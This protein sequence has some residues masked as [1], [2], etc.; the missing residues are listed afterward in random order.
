ME[1][2]ELNQTELDILEILHRVQNEGGYWITLADNL[3]PIALRM[4]LTTGYCIRDIGNKQPAGFTL[5]AKGLLYLSK[6]GIEI[7]PK[8]SIWNWES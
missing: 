4:A 5:T 6:N 8:N 1:W 3:Q 2:V 7:D